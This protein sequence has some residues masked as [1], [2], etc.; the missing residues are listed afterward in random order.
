MRILF[1]SILALYA[2]VVA[3]VNLRTRHAGYHLALAR[4]GATLLLSAA[5]AASTFSTTAAGALLLVALAVGVS[6]VVIGMRRS[7]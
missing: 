4:S 1:V 7:N 2:I 3:A 5:L 6:F